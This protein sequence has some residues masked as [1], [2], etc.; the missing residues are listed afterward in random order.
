MVLTLVVG[1]V[2]LVLAFFGVA[3]LLTS[4]FAWARAVAWQESDVEDPFRSRHA[5]CRVGRR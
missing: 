3:H 5:S 2:V 1:L 4:D